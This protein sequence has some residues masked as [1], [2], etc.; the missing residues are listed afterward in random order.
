[1]LNAREAARVLNNLFWEGHNLFGSSDG[2]ALS[3]FV[4]ELFCGDDPIDSDGKRNLSVLYRIIIIE[5]KVEEQFNFNG[6]SDTHN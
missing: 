4:Q 1:M 5:E 6:K 2:P 3:N